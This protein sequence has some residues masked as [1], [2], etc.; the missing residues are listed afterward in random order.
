LN[1]IVD[2]VDDDS[3]R[4]IVTSNLIVVGNDSPVTI[5]SVSF[6]TQQLVRIESQWFIERRSVRSGLK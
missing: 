6:I 1:A 3:D 2:A 5:A 4:A